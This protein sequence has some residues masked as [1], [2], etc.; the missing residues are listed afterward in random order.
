[1]DRAA[2]VGDCTVEECAVLESAFQACEVV[3]ERYAPGR[4]KLAQAIALLRSAIDAGELPDDVDGSVIDAVVVLE[5]C[6]D[7]LTELLGELEARAG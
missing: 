6:D 7:C 2:G 5:E 3:V 1:L 4:R